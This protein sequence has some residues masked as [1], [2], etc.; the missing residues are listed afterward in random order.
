[1]KI[2]FRVPHKYV[3]LEYKQT[4]IKLFIFLWVIELQMFSTFKGKMI[5]ILPT[6]II[7]WHLPWWV[8]V[9]KTQAIYKNLI[10]RHLFGYNKCNA[11]ITKE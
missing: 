7:I 2:K 11:H 5:E 1:M 8:K 9:L 4:N 3:L 10:S 6:Q